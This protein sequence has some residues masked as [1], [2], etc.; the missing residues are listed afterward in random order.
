[1]T[2]YASY[3]P[4][5]RIPN[6]PKGKIVDEN[7]YPTVEE[8]TFRQTLLTLLQNNLGD[9]G[10]VVTSLSQSNINQIVNNTQTMTV[11]GNPS[12]VTYTCPFGT[13]FYN[14]D[15]PSMSNPGGYGLQVTV[16][17]GGGVPVLKT[18][19]IS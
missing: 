6:L 2:D 19:T 10:T 11:P 13:L 5:I 17:N 4:N 14:I 3:N 8:Q 16:N 18:V 1:M 12:I 9:M 7:G 15:A